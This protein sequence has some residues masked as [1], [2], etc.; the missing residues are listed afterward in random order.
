VKINESR[1]GIKGLAFEAQMVIARN[2]MNIG[3]S[4]LVGR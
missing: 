1:I 2:N 4:K 3:T